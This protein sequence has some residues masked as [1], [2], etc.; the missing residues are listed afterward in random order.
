MKTNKLAFLLILLSL[1]LG[2]CAAKPT[3][4]AE[5]ADSPIA[6]VNEVA[7]DKDA[8][9]DPL[10][11]FNR[12]M[13]DFNYDI[14]DKFLIKPLTKGYIYV[15]P[16]PVRTG[17]LNAANNIE[18]P[19][20]SIN[21]MLQ[22]K[23]ESGFISVGR[24]A[25]NSTIGL[26][27]IFDVASNMGL[28]REKEDFGEVLGVWGVGTG[29]YLMLPGLGPYDVR[30]ITGKVVD[31]YYWPSTVIEDP[32]LIAAATVS[33]LETRAALL[34][35]EENLNRSLD[36]YLFVRDAYFQNLAFKV[37]DGKIKQKSEQELE[38]E[39]D[40]FSDFEDLLNGID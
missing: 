21:N 24:F 4:L 23:F 20:N 31:S 14:L 8:V 2:G 34:E 22:G 35:Q 13:W 19:A 1:S 18:E 5:K 10:E 40:D 28:A 25:I 26:L 29:P 27:G 7:V 3:P 36:P 11:P 12:L 16:Q 39:Q 38:E 37:S 33:L 30:S 9:Y 15:T 6:P 17:L 32:Y